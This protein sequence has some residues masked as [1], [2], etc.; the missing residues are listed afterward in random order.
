MLNYGT[1]LEIFNEDNQIFAFYRE[2]D[3]EKILVLLNFSDKVSNINV[4]SEIDSL[5]NGNY[6]I[7]L[8]NYN[9]TSV[10]SKLEP[11]ESYILKVM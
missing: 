8:S 3:K 4:V 10:E 9:R 7:L 5:S 2:Y 6:E 11:Y 1:F